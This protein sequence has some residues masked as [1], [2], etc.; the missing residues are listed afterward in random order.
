MIRH[1]LIPRFYVQ[2]IVRVILL[3]LNALLLAFSISEKLGWFTSLN[4][5]ILLMVQVYLFIHYT[6]RINR[7]LE[8]FFFSL[9]DEGSSLSFGKDES[10]K[11]LR[12]LYEYFDEINQQ[13]KKLQEQNARRSHYFHT[14]FQYVGVGLLSFYENGRIENINKAALSLLGQKDLTNI[15]QLS[16]V[17]PE[18]PRL[19][20]TLAAGKQK[21]IKFRRGP[22]LVQ[23][24]LKATE[25]VNDHTKIK[26][27]SLQNISME[28]EE[29]ELDS[30]QKLIR[31]LTHEIMNSVAPISSTIE[32]MTGFFLDPQSGSPVDISHVDKAIIDNTLLGL[33]I[34][35]ERSKGLVEFIKHYR[36]LTL[37]PK[38]EFKNIVLQEL[39]AQIHILLK[40]RLD[41]E[42]ITLDFSV[43]PRNLVLVAD[44]KLVEQVLINLINNSIESLI[45]TNRGKKLIN[46]TAFMNEEQRVFLK[47]T[48]NGKGIAPELIDQIFV[49]FFS[50]KEEGTGIGLSLSR[51]VMRLHQG[52]LNVYSFPDKETT[53]TLVF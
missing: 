11:S 25:L 35:G 3:T 5:G 48:D 29:K 42:Q 30:W 49:P 27:I 12:R 53:F 23:L 34:I 36:R 10:E 15:Q 46:I 37:L 21:L 41:K 17:D 20:S 19:M 18:L 43:Q 4:L 32:T 45:L 51:Q 24:A 40:E 6:N 52:S 28:L 26:L 47:V 33:G 7:I 50:T 14:V 38:P 39:L 44:K 31:V 1:I 9:K 8:K 22:E 16:K 13:I 2:V